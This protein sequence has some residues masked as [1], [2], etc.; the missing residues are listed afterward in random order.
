MTSQTEAVVPFR[1]GRRPG[2]AEPMAAPA[3]SGP[4]VLLA[5]VSEFQSQIVDAVYLAW[6][7]AIVVR[8]AYG[9]SHDD[10]AWYGGERRALLHAGGVRFL[11]I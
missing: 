11:G 7:K 3:F 10:R 8:A 5:D 6:S 2:I 1:A 9:D 4:H